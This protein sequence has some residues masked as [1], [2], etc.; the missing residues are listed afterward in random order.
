MDAWQQNGNVPP[1]EK[2]PGARV[3]VRLKH[4][5]PA[6]TEIDTVL[7]DTLEEMTEALARVLQ[8]EAEVASPPREPIERTEGE[9]QPADASQA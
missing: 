4:S 6:D 2:R 5:L 9:E 3:R 7:P 1:E 8:N